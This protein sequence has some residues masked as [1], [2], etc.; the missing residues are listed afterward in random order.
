MRIPATLEVKKRHDDD[1]GMLLRLFAYVMLFLL[2]ATIGVASDLPP[3]EKKEDL[4]FRV[5][6]QANK[7]QTVAQAV[8]L[9]K[10]KTVFLDR[11]VAE[12][13][14]MISQYKDKPH[15]EP[16]DPASSS[17]TRS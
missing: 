9:V 8:P 10:E 7:K 2:A 17:G 1:A 12:S 11:A 6:Q 15:F 16:R 14:A 3:S 5:N 13:I 4:L